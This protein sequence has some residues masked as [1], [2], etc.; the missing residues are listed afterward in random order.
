MYITWKS[1]GFIR[2]SVVLVRT[3]WWKIFITCIIS[4]GW[5]WRGHWSLKKMLVRIMFLK[6]IIFYFIKKY[7][8][9]NSMKVTSTSWKQSKYKMTNKSKA[10]NH[11]QIK[12]INYK[13]IIKLKWENHVLFISTILMHLYLLS[14]DLHSIRHH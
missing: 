1:C 9:T 13:I 11:K 2:F 8:S 7:A 10:Q 3:L 5:H 6:N 4:V 14:I 12:T